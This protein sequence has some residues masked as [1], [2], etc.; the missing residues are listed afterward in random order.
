ME[1]EPPEWGWVAFGAFGGVGEVD[2]TEETGLELGEGCCVAT[3]QEVVP[4]VTEVGRG[5]LV[6]LGDESEGGGPS[7]GEVGTVQVGGDGIQDDGQC[8]SRWS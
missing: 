7:G 6:V 3:F 5:D 2:G 4:A 1:E 8:G